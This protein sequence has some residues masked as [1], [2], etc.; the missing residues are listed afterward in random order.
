LGADEYVPVA[1]ALTSMTVTAFVLLFLG[2]AMVDGLQT[3]AVVARL[4]QL[5]QA[6]RQG[7]VLEV[8]AFLRAFGS[9]HL[10]PPAAEYAGTLVSAP[11]SDGHGEPRELRTTV[12]PDRFFGEFTLVDDRLLAGLFRYFPALLWSLGFTVLVA[13]LLSALA[14]FRG[15]SATVADAD[16]VL[17]DLLFSGAEVGLMAMVVPAAVA[18]LVGLVQR[19]VLEARYRQ[20]RRLRQ[21]VGALFQAYT[22]EV[23]VSLALEEAVRDL[24]A[25]LEQCTQR[26]A[27]AIGLHAKEIGARTMGSAPESIPIPSE[28]PRASPQVAEP[29][30]R[31]LRVL[32]RGAA[33]FL[34]EVEKCGGERPSDAARIP[35]PAAPEASDVLEIPG[36]R[37][38]SERQATTADMTSADLHE[39][40]A[41]PHGEARAVPG[42]RG[43]SVAAARETPER[44]ARLAGGTGRG[45]DVAGNVSLDSGASPMS[46]AAPNASAKSELA[47]AIR[48]LCEDTEFIIKNLP[49]LHN[50][51][52][53]DE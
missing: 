7:K 17:Y 40:S 29:G 35:R 1:V 38:P 52:S 43:D 22:L 4:R 39:A 27:D 48:A 41:E 47:R 8:E 23:G 13:S 51:Q 36:E 24:R 44:D 9:T 2:L 49:K 3:A 10:A 28:S 42:R 46:D 16:G 18:P 11:G 6:R 25:E 26:L 15:H 32:K 19:G 20:V 21:G 31:R 37:T 5:Q 14:R 34:S 45:G 30:E 33:A 50:T 12:S 53:S